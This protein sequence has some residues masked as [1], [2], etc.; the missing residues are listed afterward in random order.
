M[1][2][3]TA[4]RGSMVGLVLMLSACQGAPRDGANA[5]LEERRTQLP[6]PAPAKSI[7][8]MRYQQ[9]AL[10][11][12]APG[13]EWA[14]YKG[15][16]KGHPVFVNVVSVDPRDP[17]YRVMVAPAEGP[18]P[19]R[20][21]STRQ[22][23]KRQS[24][25]AGINGSY[26]HFNNSHDGRPIGLVKVFGEVLS[27]PRGDRPAL[28]VA[29]DGTAFFGMPR[30]LT[31]AEQKAQLAKALLPTPAPESEPR[32]RQWL[33]NLS[34]APKPAKAAPE[35]KRAPTLNEP[36]DDAPFALEGGPLLVQAGELKLSAGFDG[37]IMKAREPRTAVG[38]MPDGKLL[39]VTVDGRVPGHSKG[40]A[41][42]ELAQ[43]FLELGATEAL[44][45]D[46]GG[47]T[48]M[49]VKGDLVS[50]VSTGWCRPVSNALL[51]VPNEPEPET[52]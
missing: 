38:L 41:L 50:R 19:T 43:F 33:K 37:Y 48:T 36:W 5:P 29:P 52:P 15:Q 4:L 20:R 45:W 10:K 40:I 18:G 32:W 39:L 47:S 11:E 28:G 46:G 6:S 14:Q 21:E 42:A 51:I 44:N 1:L 35:P 12:I 2:S 23:A 3:S 49:M 7:P 25:I 31:P 30:R 8:P 22:I 24:A 16:E 26:F 17:R 13:V 9:V 27:E 34:G